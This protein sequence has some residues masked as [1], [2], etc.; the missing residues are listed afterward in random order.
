MTVS[1][2]WKSIFVW[3][4]HYYYLFFVFI[5]IRAKAMYMLSPVRLTFTA[6]PWKRN[7]FSH[8]RQFLVAE[9]REKKELHLTAEPISR[10]VVYC[11]W[12]HS[13]HTVV[14]L[15]IPLKEFQSERFILSW[16]ALHPFIGPWPIFQFRNLYTQSVDS[17]DGGSAH[18]KAA[19]YTQNST[20]TE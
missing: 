6:F 3:F 19:A 8:G 18:R 15:K 9:Y 16:V 12:V 2:L 5:R 17:S 13:A 10:K 4:Y 11:I 7:R 1:R 20:T 14:F